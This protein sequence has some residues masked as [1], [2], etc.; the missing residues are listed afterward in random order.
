MS[1]WTFVA[2]IAVALIAACTIIIVAII[3]YDSPAIQDKNKP[4]NFNIKDKE[5]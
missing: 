4:N 5:Q 1:V 2:V 3:R